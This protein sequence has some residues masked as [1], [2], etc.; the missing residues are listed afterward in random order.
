MLS[1][2][3][4]C[5]LQAFL[6]F[7]LAGLHAMNRWACKEDLERLLRKHRRSVSDPSARADEIWQSMAEHLSK[8]NVMGER[9]RFVASASG[10]IIVEYLFIHWGAFQ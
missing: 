9:R 2:V 4:S 1:H 10:V 7:A 8:N 3:V 5:Y 6:Q